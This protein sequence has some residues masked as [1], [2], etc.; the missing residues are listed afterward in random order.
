MVV[1]ISVNTQHTTSS[2]HVMPYEAD[3]DTQHR[4][5]PQNISLKFIMR[6][7]DRELE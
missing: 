3:K 1:S 2:V 4:A 6:F 5:G 7:F